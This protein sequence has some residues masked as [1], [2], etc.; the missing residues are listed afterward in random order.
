MEYVAQKPC[1]FAGQKF[2]I[3]DEIPGDLIH[4]GAAMNLVK[5][6]VIAKKSSTGT[7]EPDKV[8]IVIHAEEGDLPLDVTPE[9]MQAV[10]DVLTGKATDAEET[11]DKMIDGDALILIH[12]SSTRKSVKD[13]AETRAKQLNSEGEQ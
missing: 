13:A 6:G 11:I 2:K 5:M 1:C 4:P 7:N 10:F 3:H 8:H 12:L 9:G